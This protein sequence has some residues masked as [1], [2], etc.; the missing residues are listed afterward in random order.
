MTKSLSSSALVSV[1]GSQSIGSSSCLFLS[2]FA[3]SA[4]SDFDRYLPRRF[5]SSSR[6]VPA[7]ECYAC[8]NFVGGGASVGVFV[9]C[10]FNGCCRLRSRIVEFA[11]E[12]QDVRGADEQ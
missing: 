5:G 1:V 9:R 8:E 7:R 11:R 10:R 3:H 2:T 4:I 12:E 6:G